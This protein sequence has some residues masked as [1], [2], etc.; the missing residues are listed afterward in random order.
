MS[1]SDDV[2]S[3]IAELAKAK[4]A[5]T[6][7]TGP[8]SKRTYIIDSV[9]LSEEELI[10]LHSKGALTRDGIRRYFVYRA[11]CGPCTETTSHI[12]FITLFHHLLRASPLSEEESCHLKQCPQCQALTEELAHT[13]SGR[14][15]LV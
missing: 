4:M 9:R 14:I 10:L 12:S 3:A 2:T 15:D 5:F 11:A 13:D 8:D 1:A 7:E 6:S